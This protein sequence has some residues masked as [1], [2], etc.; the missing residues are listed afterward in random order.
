MGE[1]LTRRRGRPLREPNGEPCTMSLTVWLPLSAYD[2]LTR[3][4]RAKGEDLSEFVRRNYLS[5]KSTAHPA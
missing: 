3:E 4:A 2:R 5:D 1:P